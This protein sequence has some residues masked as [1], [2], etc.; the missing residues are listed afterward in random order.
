ME[1]FPGPMSRTESDRF[2]DLIEEEFEREGF[3]LWAVEVP[4]VTEFAGFAGLHRVSFEA[5]FVP[6]VEAGWRLARPYWGRGYATEAAREALRR[7]FEDHGLDEIVAF[8]I[9]ANE[10]SQRVMQ[11]LGMTHDPRDDFDHP[12]FPPG[13]RLSRHVLYRARRPPTS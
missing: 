11:R 4:G 9:P 1:H 6:A 3:G 2:A 8:T 7:G 13:H 10:R 12:R 5:P